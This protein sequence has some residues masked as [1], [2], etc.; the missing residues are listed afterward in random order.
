MCKLSPNI[1]S[2]SFYVVIIKVLP[3]AL[4]VC[5]V[6]LMVWLN[7]IGT[8]K[9]RWK[10]EE[11]AC[12][13]SLNSRQHYKHV[14]QRRK[15]EWAAWCEACGRVLTADLLLIMQLCPGLDLAAPALFASP[16]L[17]MNQQQTQDAAYTLLIEIFIRKPSIFFHFHSSAFLPGHIVSNLVTYV[18]WSFT[19]QMTSSAWQL[20][21]HIYLSVL[22]HSVNKY[23]YVLTV[24]TSF[25]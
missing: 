15:I 23:I 12:E 24:D 10:P 21:N 25:R 20:D 22:G 2:I 17:W 7:F 4:C 8:K 19:S 16:G 3:D 11:K 13:P 1:S 9:K 18:I 14:S 5:Y 6:L